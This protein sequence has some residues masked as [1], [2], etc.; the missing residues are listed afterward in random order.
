MAVGSTAPPQPT[1][2]STLEKL[3]TPCISDF[4]TW[5]LIDTAAHAMM[6]DSR[7]AVWKSFMAGVT[8]ADDCSPVRPRECGRT[9]MISG[10]RPRCST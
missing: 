4:L 9:E 3:R 1:V 2:A 10:T 6:K 5:A 7:D 8:S